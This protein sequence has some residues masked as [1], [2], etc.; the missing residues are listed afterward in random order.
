[1][2]NN[3]T[4]FDNNLYYSLLLYN[5]VAFPKKKK[6]MYDFNGRG[7]SEKFGERLFQRLYFKNFV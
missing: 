7:F 1:M 5:K 2:Y 3:K 6:K 4:M